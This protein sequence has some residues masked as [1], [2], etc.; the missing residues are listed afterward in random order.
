MRGGDEGGGEDEEGGDEEGGDEEGI[1]VSHLHHGVFS[2]RVT[3]G[4]I[5]GKQ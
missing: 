5:I 4:H 1:G 3:G 2:S